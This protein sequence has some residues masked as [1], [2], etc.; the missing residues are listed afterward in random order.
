MFFTAFLAFTLR[1]L[2]VH[3]NKM[4]DRKQ[5]DA[6][7]QDQSNVTAAENYGPYFSYVL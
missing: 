5:G 2:L 1:S 3:D 4:L 6:T 7:G